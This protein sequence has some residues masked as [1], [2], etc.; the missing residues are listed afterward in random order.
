MAPAHDQSQG[1]NPEG[2]PALKVLQPTGFEDSIPVVATISG[3]Q[4]YQIL[5][6]TTSVECITQA[7]RSRP[8]SCGIPRNG[9]PHVTSDSQR[10][11][12][13]NTFDRERRTAVR[14]TTDPSIASR[15]APSI[16]PEAAATP[17]Q[18][19]EPQL[20][21]QRHPEGRPSHPHPHSSLRV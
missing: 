6:T 17:H 20:H 1:F 8:I 21:P 7:F 5:R 13:K 2:Y 12:R 16:H 4:A 15:S 18:I 11:H 9:R 19:P 14:F 10:C 3:S